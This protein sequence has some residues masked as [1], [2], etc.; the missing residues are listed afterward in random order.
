[1]KFIA[2][3][4]LLFASVSLVAC[5]SYFPVPNQRF[6]SPTVGGKTWKGNV[7]GGYTSPTYVQ[8]V[9]N[10][11]ASPPLSSGSS[12][13]RHPNDFDFFD[14]V[15]VDLR[16]GL[17]ERFEVS[18]VGQMTHFKFQFLGD[19]RLVHTP[20]QW[21]G[22]VTADYL[23][24]D[25]ENSLDGSVDSRVKGYGLGTSVI[26][27]YRTS[28]PWIYFVNLN[29]ID[30]NAKTDITQSSTK[31]RY[32]GDGRQVGA[33]LGARYEQEQGF[34]MAAEWSYSKTNWSGASESELGSFGGILGWAW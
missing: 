32:E 25:N 9:N 31:Y 27:G 15:V 30:F 33:S 28:T 18:N 4:A 26:I 8:T 10:T 13:T 16:F 2:R 5:A 21:V 12:V 23:K 20:D 17:G 22:S 3:L 29:Y 14:R 1:M 11:D 34:Y 19:T 24:I 7:G 6:D